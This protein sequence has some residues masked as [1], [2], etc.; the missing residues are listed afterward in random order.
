[1]IVSIDIGTSYSSICMLGPDGKAHPV[2]ISTGAS[3]FGSK[4]SLPSAVFVE[5]DGNIL[6]GQAAMNSRKHKPQNFHKEFKRD[7]GQDIPVLLGGRSFKPEELYTELFR[8][9]KERA[10]KLTEEP[11]DRAYLTYPASYG[12]QR[13]EKLCAAANAAGLFDLELVDEPTAAAMCYCAEG[14][15]KDG[16]TLLVY[17][18]GGG[19]F[20]VS[21]IRYENGTFQ[22]LAEPVGLEQCGGMDIDYLI[23]SDMRQAIE[24]ELPGAWGELEKN[25]NRFRRFASQLS[26][27]AV[28]AK[29]HLSSANSFEEYIEVGMDD[30]RYQLDTERFNAMIASLVGQTVQT[31][32]RALDEAGVAASEV[33]AVLLVGGTSRIPLVQE[34]AGKI[35]GKPALCAAD[36]ELIVAQGALMYRETRTAPEKAEA[37]EETGQE[38]QAPEE[39]EEPED[40]GQ[41]ARAGEY[42]KLGESAEEQQK[43]EE[44]AEYYRKAAEAGNV[45]AMFALGVCYAKG[46]GVLRDDG[47]SAQ[48]LRKAAE[49]GYV[50]AMCAL[51][52]Y[53]AEGRGVAKDDGQAVQWCRKAAEAGED[54]AMYN[55]GV[56]YEIG[57]G[58]PQD[59]GQAV[60][61]FR[62]AAEAGK[63]KAMFA[64]GVRYYDGQGVPQDDRQAAQWFRKAAE[65]GHAVAMYNLGV[66]YENG[67]GVPQ[68]DGQ[69]IQWYRKAAEA[70][71]ADAMYSLGW[72]YAKGQGVPQDDGQAAQW[73]REAAEAGDVRAMYSLGW[74]YRLGEGVDLD[75]GRAAQ[76]YRKAAEAGHVRAM[77]NLGG[78]YY[79]GRGVPQ[80]YGQAAQW[81]REASEAGDADAMYYLGVFYE[82]G[83]GV[84]QDF[85]QALQWYREAAEAGNAD[86]AKRLRSLKKQGKC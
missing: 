29:H 34:M 2:D 39:P 23:A 21:L 81:F 78:C 82:N 33:S 24:K 56:Y 69:A 5:D 66:C 27:C 17:D 30:V 41:A 31:C 64:L 63:V 4:Y 14:Y 32:R 73:Y 55:L 86:A 57:Q 15:V 9:M 67:Q 54:T 16:Q 20:D 12:K 80:D 38:T 71:N 50:N 26:E 51:G 84:P 52:M 45:N 59:D 35:T 49:L 53:Y 43:W 13:R 8:H 47:Q 25:E 83:Q 62:K 72:C 79:N 7:L 74:C 1:M 48:W 42:F 44:A 70:G 65:A 11:I 22:L 19:T 68:D 77:Y 60:L 37:P 28:K 46:Q 10:E 36:L 58:V 3:M 76:W 40:A 85:A 61:W 75:D 6:V 18:F